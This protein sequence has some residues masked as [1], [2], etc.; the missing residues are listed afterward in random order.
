MVGQS[1][2]SRDQRPETAIDV[3]SSDVMAP[4]ETGVVCPLQLLD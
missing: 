3:V 4:C 2:V 1:E